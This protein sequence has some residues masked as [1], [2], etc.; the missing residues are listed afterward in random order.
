MSFAK[1][2]DV[3]A[4]E[5]AKATRMPNG[6]KVYTYES[7]GKLCLKIWMPRALKPL[8]YLYFPTSEPCERYIETLMNNF[9][10]SQKQKIADRQARAIGDLTLAD[11]GTIFCYSW[12]YDQTNV[13]YFQVVKRSGYIVYLEPIGCETIAG[14]EGFMCETVRPC[15]DAFLYP[16]KRCG[17]FKLHYNHTCDEAAPGRYHEFEPQE[18]VRRKVTFSQSKPYLAFPHGCGSRVEI[19]QLPNG[20]WFATETH[21]RSHYA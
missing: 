16:C 21:Y 9:D 10:Q 19:M 15:R 3:W 1:N 6:L 14:S 13:E 17:I 11:P 18:P 12:G 8:V 5:R 20:E 7:A 2:I 4:Q